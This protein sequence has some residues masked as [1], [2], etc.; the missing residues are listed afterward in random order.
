VGGEYSET[1]EGSDGP[2]G[3]SLRGGA[4]GADHVRPA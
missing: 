4:Q 2:E 3:P 1:D